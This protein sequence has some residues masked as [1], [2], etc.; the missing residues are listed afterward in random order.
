MTKI[1]LTPDIMEGFVASCL[2]ERYDQATKVPQFH[3]EL[4]ELFCSPELNVAVACPRGHAKTTAGTQAFTMAN[5]LFRQRK[6]VL[7]VSDTQAQAI[8]FLDEIKTN[9]LENDSIINSFGK[10]K[11]EKDTTEDVI[12]IF[13]DGAKFRIQAKGAEQ[14]LRGLKWDSLRPD[15]ICID[16]LENDELV[17]NQDRRDKLRRWFYGALLP[18][19]AKG[20]LI[21]YVGTILHMDALLERIIYENKPITVDDLRQI[22]KPNKR[23]TWLTARYKAHNPTFTQTLWPERYDGE[24]FKQ[25][26]EDFYKQGLMDVYSQEY[27]NYPV[28]PTTAFYRRQDFIAMEPKDHSKYKHYYI[29]GDL[30]VSTSQ[31]AD[32][33][34]FVVA[35][36]DEDGIIHIV[37]VIRDRIDSME[38][39][40]TLLSLQQRYRP[41]LVCLEKGHI[42]KSVGPFLRERMLNSGIFINLIGMQPTQDKVTRARS[43][44]AR[45]RAGAV[46]IDKEADWYYVYE[47]EMLTFPRGK[48]DDM[49]DATSYIGLSLDQ[50]ISAPTEEELEDGEWE[51]EFGSNM[52][53]KDLGANSICGY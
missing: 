18:C 6:Y 14:K 20:G 21:R 27:L 24:Y 41:E 37:D 17:M 39:V 34:V 4:W 38:M 50:L 31:K 44:Q 11:F 46:R 2:A 43:M 53:A 42:E 9:L 35:G 47:E 32:Y 28:D 23:N 45:F 26:K 8:Q 22:G 10:I 25:L 15:L 29:A 12:G 30:A 48:H 49:V 7:I 19:R 40:E 33:T 51:E 52:S 3:R 16:D 36:V 5:I 13:E 1:T